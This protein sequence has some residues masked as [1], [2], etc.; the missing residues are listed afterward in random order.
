MKI[1]DLIPWINSG[2]DVSPQ[3]EPAE[4]FRALR[5]DIDRAFEQFWRMLPSSFPAPASAASDSIR[6]DVSDSDKAVT[7]T[8]ELPGLSEETSSFQSVTAP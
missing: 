8:A 7:I 5:Q 1:T 4:P 2:R 6:V 3:T